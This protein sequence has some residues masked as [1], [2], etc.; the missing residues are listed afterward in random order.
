MT[1]LVNGEGCAELG[2]DGSNPLAFVLN[3]P[4]GHPPQP[5]GVRGEAACSPPSLNPPF[6]SGRTGL[7]P[8]F[9]PKDIYESEDQVHGDHWADWTGS[10]C[11]ALL[12]RGA[13]AACC[14]RSRQRRWPLGGRNRLVELG[15]D[16][17]LYANDPVG[18]ADA[19][20][21]FLTSA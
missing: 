8:D 19:V 21:D 10:A 13:E 15:T 17:F 3:L 4:A 2:L 6:A 7:G 11:P 5:A 1:A 20:R 16:H 18:F 14:R 12:I 9:H